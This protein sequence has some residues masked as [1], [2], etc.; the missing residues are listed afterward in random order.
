MKL[1]AY[2]VFS[3]LYDLISI[4]NVMAQGSNSEPWH[5][6][7]DLSSAIMLL[8][9]I[10]LLWMVSTLIM[11]LFIKKNRLVL[12]PWHKR[13]AFATLIIACI[14]AILVLISY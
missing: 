9:I 3:I 11:G 13:L 5:S 8:G 10:T 1:K 14:H 12:L 2:I 6:Q 7:F 4:S